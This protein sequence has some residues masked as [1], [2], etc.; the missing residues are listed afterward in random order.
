MSTLGGTTSAAWTLEWSEDQGSTWTSL[1]TKAGAQLTGG[2]GSGPS[3]AA[4]ASLELTWDLGSVTGA[5]SVVDWRLT[6]ECTGSTNGHWT[7]RGIGFDRLQISVTTPFSPTASPT[8]TSPTT[9]S[10]TTY[11]CNQQNKQ[12]AMYTSNFRTRALPE[13]SAAK[14]LLKPRTSPRA[15]TLTMSTRRRSARSKRWI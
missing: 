1:G 4:T 5:A 11:S 12:K 9:A 7:Q 15:G 8:T 6:P 13:A 10:P 14:Q 2:G 3:D